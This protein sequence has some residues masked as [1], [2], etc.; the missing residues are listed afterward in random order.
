[1]SWIFGYIGPD[2]SEGIEKKFKPIHA[3]PLHEYK[4][5]KYYIT[6]GGID[7]TCL[8]ADSVSGKD[9]SYKSGWIV[10][11]LGIKL[12]SNNVS[13][14]SSEDWENILSKRNPEFKNIDGH[15]VIVRWNEQNIEIFNDQLGLRTFYYCECLNG[16]AFSTRL[17][18]LAKLIKSP[19]LD[20]EAFGP[21]WMLY[22]QLTFDSFIKGIKRL[23][24]GGRA[25]CNPKSV[26]VQTDFWKPEISNFS[27]PSFENLV[28]AYVNPTGIKDEDISFGLSGGL[29]S[30]FLLS[31]FRHN[32][33]NVSIHNWGRSEH[34]DTKIARQII[35]A[36]NLNNSFTHLDEP[37]PTTGECAKLLWDYE[38]HACI[39]E[40]ASSI[41]KLRH[42]S[43]LRA[44][45]KILID[46]G[47]GEIFRRIHHNV[48]IY[49]GK[50]ELRSGDPVR[51]LP[52]L[53]VDRGE[54]FNTD[55]ALLMQNG[56]HKQINEI[57]STLPSIKE[58]GDENF[59]ELFAIRTRLP[60]WG[61][62]EQSRLD[63]QILN[64]MPLAQPTMINN[65][66]NIP[67][68]ERNH[69]KLFRNFIKKYTLSLT[70]YPIVR[71]TQ[72]HPFNMRSPEIYI[73]TRLK[74]KLGI[75]YKNLSVHIFLELMKEFI[76]DTINSASVKNYSAYNYT[77]LSRQIEEYYRGNKNL[78]S[79]IDWWLSFEIWRNTLSL[80]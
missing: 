17:D 39:N 68:K 14:L 60:N 44:N 25:V 76:F 8:S 53:K 55:T 9:F 27:S 52:F 74:S 13:F 15:F 22:N 1:M 58:L 40:P 62:F 24:P 26:S 54:I 50:K 46:G 32:K 38:S 45:G 36:E 66:F 16:T 78:S 73:W 79:K 12:N 6:A 49:R 56:I 42:F 11:G 75:G 30:R 34:P 51:L 37:Y 18:W 57:Y 28:S 5:D 77:E 71:G 69:G 29:D 31:L 35:D 43:N 21:R 20:F 4:S 33:K 61:A 64:F 41:L 19:E 70:K 48:I 63:H 23:P 65:V 2:I 67:V 7:E 10:T 59:L 80:K 47:F 72:T 3:N